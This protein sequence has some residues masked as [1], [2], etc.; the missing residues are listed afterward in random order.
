MSFDGSVNFFILY[1]YASNS[2]LAKPITGLDIMSIFTA[3]KTYFEELTAKGFKP[4]LNIMDNQ[5]T[6]HIKK[7]LTKNKCKLQVIEPHNHCVNATKRAIQMFKAA[8][9]TALI[10]TDSDFSL[11]LWDR[12]TPQVK[13]TLNMLPATGTD[14]TKSAYFFLTDLMNETGTRWPPYGAKQLSM[15]TVT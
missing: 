13:D 8:F 15:K 14:P 3:Y 6:N 12:L 10:T 7:I 2:I 1:H 9:I 4:Q 11:L 5:A